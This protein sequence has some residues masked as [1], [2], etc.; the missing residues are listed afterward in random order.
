MTALLITVLIL[1]L[2]LRWLARQLVGPSTRPQDVV[3]VDTGENDRILSSHRY[4]MTGQPESILDEHGERCAQHSSR[5][6]A[7]LTVRRNQ[8]SAVAAAVAVFA[9]R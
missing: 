6:C 8:T 5:R 2:V 7:A 1:A 9:G 4:R 3:H